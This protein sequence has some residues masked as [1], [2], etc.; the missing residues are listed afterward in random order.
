MRV[1][2]L[3]C[4]T[5]GGHISSAV[6]IKEEF[7]S[8]NV[9][10]DIVDSLSF[11]SEKMS[12]FICN[13]HARIYRSMPKVF[14]NGYT[15]AENRHKIFDANKV[16]YKVLSTG[17]NKFHQIMQN[18][19]YDL[20]ICTHTI[21]CPIVMELRARHDL[22]FR[23]CFVAT[24]YTCSPLVDESDLELY[25]I[26]HADLTDEFELNGIPREKVFP[27]G[28]PVRRDFLGKIE[29]TEA[30]KLLGIPEDKGNVLLMGGSMGCGPMEDLAL[31][32]SE[33][34]SESA[35]LTVVCG[36][37]TKLLGALG[38]TKRKNIRALGYA[39]NIPLLMDA[40]DIFLTKPGGASISEAASK[41]L[42]ML[43]INTVGG[44]EGRNMD[45]FVERGW[46]E[47][48][49]NP[50]DTASRCG[51]LFRNPDALREKANRLNESFCH[52]PAGVIYEQLSAVTE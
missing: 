22:D 32:L 13:W 29:K 27:S 40:A 26:P 37:N 9:Q 8:H 36:T 15:Y 48:F 17:V 43:F 2:I 16:L 34:L 50:G 23:A 20:I 14:K 51:E 4:N 5:G 10:C 21:C 42:P 49:E 52:N 11:M 12:E 38:A 39:N 46:A 31:R 35:V 18:G 24:D 7:N 45:F 33:A 6:A 3:T 19:G 1:L 44:C 41:N 25:F 47:A 30:K 28:V